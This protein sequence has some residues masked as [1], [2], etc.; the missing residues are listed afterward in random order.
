MENKTRVLNFHKKTST[1]QFQNIYLV[2][3][4]HLPVIGHI[5]NV[6]LILFLTTTSRALQFMQQ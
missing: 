6:L 1:T 5:K 3:V 4:V 2:G